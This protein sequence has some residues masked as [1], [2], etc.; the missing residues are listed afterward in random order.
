MT[1]RNHLCPAI[2]AKLWKP[3]TEYILKY[4]NEHTEHKIFVAWGAFA[5]N[6]LFNKTQNLDTDK[7]KLIVS[8]HPSPL[9][10]NK[11]F[12]IYPKFV[13][14]KPFTKINGILIELNKTPIQW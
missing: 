5:Y 7:H 1:S 8:S 9:S 4:L 2:H 11:C 13:D 10:A 3:F 6:C 14:S 12:Q